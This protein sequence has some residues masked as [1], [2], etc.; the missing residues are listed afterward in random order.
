M[1]LDGGAI[2]AIA[3]IGCGMVVGVVGIIAWTIV[4]LISGRRRAPQAS[5]DESRMIQ[6]IYHGLNKMEQRVETLETLLLE[7]EKR[8]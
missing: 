5:E 4:S 7:R 2:I 8:G 6:E 1:D 3:F